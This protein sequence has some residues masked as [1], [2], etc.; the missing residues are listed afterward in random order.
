M[1][2][3]HIFPRLEQK[4]IRI[5]MAHPTHDLTPWLQD[6]MAQL[7]DSRNPITRL[8]DSRT[9][10]L[11]SMTPGSH[12]ST[13]WLQDPNY[14]NQWLQNPMAQLHDHMT[15]FRDSR[16][17]WLDSKTPA[18]TLL[19]LRNIV[20]P[21][22]ANAKAAKNSC[23]FRQITTFSKSSTIFQVDLAVYLLLTAIS[24]YL[25]STKGVSKTTVMTRIHIS[26]RFDASK[27]NILSPSLFS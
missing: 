13:P 19:S 18:M 25:C 22:K 17:P 11:D 6:S 2:N 14:S 9:P 27:C 24:W 1:R 23:L 20:T 16:N 10:W 7:H 15:R 12:G 3:A 21:F 8:H 4:Q 5:R 26:S